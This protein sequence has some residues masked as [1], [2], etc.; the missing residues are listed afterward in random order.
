[1]DKGLGYIP[2]L[3]KGYHPSQASACASLDFS[4]RFFEHE[5]DLED[6]NYTEQKN[7]VASHAR[8]F[9]EG[10]V[11]ESSGRILACMTQQTILC[12]ESEIKSRY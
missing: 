12:W 11:W 7:F 4:L 3:H 6:W 1:M 2:A 10:R 5:F 8:A 9:N